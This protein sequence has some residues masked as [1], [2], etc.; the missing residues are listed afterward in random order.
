MSQC[1][2]AFVATTGSNVL[3]TWQATLTL[4]DGVYR[5]V[6][7]AADRA[8][9]LSPVSAPRTITIDTTSPSVG[10]VNLVR[11]AQP[12]ANLTLT[13]TI[14]DN[15]SGSTGPKRSWPTCPQ[16][17]RRP[18]WTLRRPAMTSTLPVCPFRRAPPKGRR[19]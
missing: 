17:A 2:Q 9:N 19:R 15:L 7:Q 5:V 11:F 3:Q 8:G 10:A 14:S 4:P 1:P 13:A 16:P 6:V 12:G 18:S